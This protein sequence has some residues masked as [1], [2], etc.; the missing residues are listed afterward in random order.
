MDPKNVTITNTSKIT[1]ESPTKR[2]R[3]Q[4]NSNNLLI[5]QTKDNTALLHKL[6]DELKT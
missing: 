5:H 4:P 6:K 2:N 1:I 3:R